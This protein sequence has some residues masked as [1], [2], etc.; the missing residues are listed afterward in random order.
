M[1]NWTVFWAFLIGWILCAAFNLALAWR[2]DKKVASVLKSVEE[3]KGASKPGD[4]VFTRAV[5]PGMYSRLVSARQ[6]SDFG[7]AALYLGER[8]GGRSAPTGEAELRVL[9]DSLRG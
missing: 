2:R 6:G 7:H 9:R 4:I 1:I 8:Y 3:L 5:E